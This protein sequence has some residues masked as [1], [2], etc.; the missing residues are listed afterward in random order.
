M[1][2]FSAYDMTA[3]AAHYVS[4]KFVFEAASRST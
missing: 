2:E 3:F 4:A 1:M